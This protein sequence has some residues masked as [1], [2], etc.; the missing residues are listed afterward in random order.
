MDQPPRK[1]ATE[2]AFRRALE[3]RLKQHVQKEGGDLL[4]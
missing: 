1:Y 2:T 3:E 4:K